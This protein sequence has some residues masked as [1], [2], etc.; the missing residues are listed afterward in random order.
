MSCARASRDA[1]T[2]RGH[3]GRERTVAAPWEPTNPETPLYRSIDRAV[4]IDGPNHAARGQAREGASVGGDLASELRRPAHD[5]VRRVGLLP[6]RPGRLLDR[7]GG[8]PACGI[9]PTALAMAADHCFGVVG[10][11]R[12]EA[13]IRPENHGLQ[14]GR[15]KARLPR[16]GRPGAAAAHQR[17]LAGPRVLRADRRGGPARADAP[18]AQLTVGVASVNVASV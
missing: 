8:S 17:G 14:A 16:R 18:V 10:L 1:R 3:P 12:L 7:R 9:I 2:W 11:H 6:V 5:R 15:G 4:R 13:W